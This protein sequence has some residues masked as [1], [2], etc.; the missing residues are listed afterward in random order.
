[1]T[2][3]AK[4]L[5]AEGMS[6]FYEALMMNDTSHALQAKILEKNKSAFHPCPVTEASGAGDCIRE[7]FNCRRHVRVLRSI[8]DGSLMMNDTSHAL[9][10]KSL[11]KK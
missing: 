5:T 9:Q 4:I 8:D 7:D 11:E 6:V 1:V 2:A 3:F 10:A